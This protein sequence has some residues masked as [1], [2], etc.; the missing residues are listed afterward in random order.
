MTGDAA[1]VSVSLQG[2]RNRFW[3]IA[4]LGIV[5]G[6]METGPGVRAGVMRLLQV[7]DELSCLIF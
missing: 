6:D 3:I 1:N 2:V 5:V 4:M 7:Y